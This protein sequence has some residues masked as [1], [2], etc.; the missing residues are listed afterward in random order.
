MSVGRTPSEANKP[1]RSWVREAVSASWQRASS[2]IFQGWER[3]ATEVEGIRVL[4]EDSGPHVKEL[5][6][7]L[8]NLSNGMVLNFA[9]ETWSSSRRE[10]E[11]QRQL[12]IESIAVHEFGHAIG[13]AL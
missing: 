13:F 9:F 4:I 7:G 5:G 6:R 11:Q 12:C 10:N 1:E 8:N 3:C 2:L